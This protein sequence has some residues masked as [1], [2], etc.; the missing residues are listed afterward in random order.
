MLLLH[1]TASRTEYTAV[2]AAGHT[3]ADILRKSDMG[4]IARRLDAA[5]AARFA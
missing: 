5:A 4:G 3:A 2:D 1:A